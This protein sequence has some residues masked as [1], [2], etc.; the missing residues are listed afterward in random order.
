LVRVDSENFRTSKIWD[1]KN[2]IRVDFDLRLAST[3]ARP[4]GFEN[5]V[6]VDD[7]RF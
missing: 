2:Y 6:L 5:P 1:Y 3:N 7:K 4:E